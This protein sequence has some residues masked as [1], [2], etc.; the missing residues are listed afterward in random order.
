MSTNSSVHAVRG[1]GISS[2][3][4]RLLLAQRNRRIDAGGAACR[5][6]GRDEREAED[7][8]GDAEIRCRVER[9]RPVGGVGEARGAGPAGKVLRQIV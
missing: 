7:A 3:V 8:D 6:P 4:G 1:C 9:R 2:R 5:L